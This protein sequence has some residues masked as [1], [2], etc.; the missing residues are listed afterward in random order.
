MLI[1]RENLHLLRH[2]TIMLS[3]CCATL[4]DNWS[5]VIFLWNG[6]IMPGVVGKYNI[7]GRFTLV[8]LNYRH[9]DDNMM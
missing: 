8:V 2:D 4:V 6:G 7:D 9:N 3:R 1:E 5:K